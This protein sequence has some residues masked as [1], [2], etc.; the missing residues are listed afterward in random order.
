MSSDLQF[1]LRAEHAVGFDTAQ[2]GLLDLEVARQLGTDHGERHFQA[3][4]HVRRAADYLEG[5]RTVADLADAQFVGVRVL[6]GA[7]YFTDHH[8]AEFAGDRGLQTRHRQTSYQLVA[9]YLRAYP[10]TQ[11]LFTE[12][13]P[14]LPID[15]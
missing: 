4:A 10:A 13:H 14:V 7:Q 8:A 11:P 5:L 9:A 1:D 12:F 6:F 3:R 15:S 2:L